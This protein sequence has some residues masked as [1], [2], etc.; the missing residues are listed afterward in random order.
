MFRIS[1]GSRGPQREELYI[2][3]HTCPYTNMYVYMCTYIYILSFPI[4]ICMY[5]CIHTYTYLV[6]VNIGVH[7][8]V[9]PMLWKSRSS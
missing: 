8:N 6:Y 1:E 7:A 9:N 4:L 2:N 5:T 3:I